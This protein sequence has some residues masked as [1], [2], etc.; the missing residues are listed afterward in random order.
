MSTTRTRTRRIG[1]IINTIMWLRVRVETETSG[2][3]KLY[4]E[5]CPYLVIQPIITVRCREL[6][7][8]HRESITALI[9]LGYKTSLVMSGIEFHRTL[10]YC[11]TRLVMM[12]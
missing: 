12:H 4:M 9:E 3:V 2:P 7:K 1:A 11:L 10:V 8:F 6:V 5:K